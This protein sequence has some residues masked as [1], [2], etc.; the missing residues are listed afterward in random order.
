VKI[1]EAVDRSPGDE[2]ER[3]GSD[4]VR[5]TVEGHGEDAFEAVDGFVVGVVRVGGGDFRAGTDFEFEEG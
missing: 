4:L 3:A 5:L 1:V 2:E